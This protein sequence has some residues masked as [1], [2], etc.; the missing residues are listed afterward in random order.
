MFYF[1]LLILGVSSVYDIKYRKIKDVINVAV[2]IMAVMKYGIFNSHLYFYLLYAILQTVF[3]L[4]LTLR[5]DFI[6]GGDI[7][8]MFANSL[9]LGF[10]RAVLGVF[11]GSMF[12]ILINFRKKK[13]VPMIPYLSVGYLISHFI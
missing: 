8:F 13:E 3:I 1:Y 7:K 12:L 11:I 10:E 2:I 5:S 4:I 6:G 9:F